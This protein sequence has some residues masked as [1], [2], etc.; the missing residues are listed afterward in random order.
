MG[1]WTGRVRKAVWA[2]AR[3]DRDAVPGAGG[4]AG[5]W[6]ALTAPAVAGELYPPIGAG[7][8]GRVA[9]VSAV[10]A[11]AVFMSRRVPAVSVVLTVPLWALG[12]VSDAGSTSPQNAPSS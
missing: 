2:S 9:A 6:A 7:A 5:L 10:P 3:A 12:D 1:R 11:A 8:L 4:D